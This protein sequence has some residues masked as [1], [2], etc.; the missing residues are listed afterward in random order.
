MCL[1]GRIQRRRISGRI[2][3]QD[4]T[5]RGA[6]IRSLDKRPD[7]CSA[8][9]LNRRAEVRRRDGT[10][11]GDRQCEGKQPPL[12]TQVVRPGGALGIACLMQGALVPRDNRKNRLAEAA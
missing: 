10:R 7:R 3:R 6:L 1:E 2:C 5:D 11:D 4:C 8:S 9:S 12:R